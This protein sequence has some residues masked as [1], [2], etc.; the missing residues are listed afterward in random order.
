MTDDTIDMQRVAGEI[1]LILKHG[2]EEEKAS[3]LT[4]IEQG[5]G[6]A[7]RQRLEAWMAEGMPG[8]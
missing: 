5:C 4:A 1:T 6:L 7:E 3:L 2:T 8:A